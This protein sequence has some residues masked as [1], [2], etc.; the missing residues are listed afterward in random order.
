MGKWDQKIKLGKIKQIY[1][2][3][4]IKVT[5][6][7]FIYKNILYIVNSMYLLQKY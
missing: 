4:Y 3:G 6:R 7:N 5:L 1:E 2:K